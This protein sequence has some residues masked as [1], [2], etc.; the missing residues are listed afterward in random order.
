ML[1]AVKSQQSATFGLKSEE[2]REIMKNV[3][4]CCDFTATSIAD[5]DQISPHFGPGN[6]QKV[7]DDIFD[8]SRPSQDDFWQL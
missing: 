3:A 4:D 5:G 6:L 8:F 2:S 7:F 1:E